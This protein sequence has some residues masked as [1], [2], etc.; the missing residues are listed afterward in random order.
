M[1]IT[2]KYSVLFYNADKGSIK[3]TYECPD[4][5][6]TEHSMTIGKYTHTSTETA[7]QKADEWL[8]DIDKQKFMDDNDIHLIFDWKIISAEKDSKQLIVKEPK[9]SKLQQIELYIN[10]TSMAEQ[11]KLDFKAVYTE[12]HPKIKNMS[13]EK[14]ISLTF[15]ALGAAYGASGAAYQHMTD[16]M[17]GGKKVET[18]KI[19]E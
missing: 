5:E 8:L 10:S 11:H 17:S 12:M 6:D 15:G 16:L 18:I 13:P 1:K 19:E 7:L 9:L 14:Q 4:F 2:V 3:E